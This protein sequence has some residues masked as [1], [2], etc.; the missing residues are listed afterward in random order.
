MV[1]RFVITS[2]F[3]YQGVTQR[4]V[5][6]LYVVVVAEY[7]EVEVV[8]SPKQVFDAD[9]TGPACTGRL[10]HLWPSINTIYRNEC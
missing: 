6:V 5:D 4:R 8:Y 1:Y 3:S 9:G 7:K 2:I 10:R